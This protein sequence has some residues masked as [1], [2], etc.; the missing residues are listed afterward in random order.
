MT[1][2]EGI[3]SST[4]IFGFAIYSYFMALCGIYVLLV[5]FFT[6]LFFGDWLSA[7]DTAYDSCYDF[8]DGYY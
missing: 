7:Y 8:I 6:S 1:Q 3:L 2:V 5:G 4:W